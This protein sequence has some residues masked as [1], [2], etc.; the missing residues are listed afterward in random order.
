MKF[1]KVPKSE[2]EKIRR[3][4]I[5]ENVFVQGYKVISEDEFLLF[6]VNVSKW[7]DY[8]IVERDAEKLPEKYFKLKDLLAKYLSG[9]ELDELTTSYDIVGD[10]IIA[11]IPEELKEKEVVNHRYNFRKRQRRS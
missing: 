10:I 6:P 11:E 5:D 1:I 2:G 4:L 3:Q 9:S 7:N 8:E